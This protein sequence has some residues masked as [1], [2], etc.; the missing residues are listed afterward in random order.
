[1]K[2]GKN[3]DNS[4]KLIE[5]EFH[6]ISEAIELLKKMPK[7][8]FDS[9]C[10]VHFKLGL[11]PKQ[12]DQ[13]L[14]YTVSLPHGTGKTVRVVAFVSDDK[15][16]EA[17]AAGATFAGTEDLIEKIE[18]GWTD[19]DVAIATPD[20]MKSLGKVA[21]NL[22]QKGLMPNPKTGTVTTDV[23]KT[24]DE[25]RKGKVEVRLDKLSNTHNIFGKLS[26]DDQKLKEN[27]KTVIKSILDSRPVGAKGTYVL[28]ISICSTMSPGVRL[29][30]NN[31]IEEIK[32]A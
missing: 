29:D 3:Y 5:K 25:I 26:F 1:M 31:V 6:T 11:D 17:K 18:K 22:G 21:K 4:F 28:S 30:V 12:A 7:L 27:L 2:R 32:G 9:S 20:Q 8:K 24:I 23:V 13:N 19:F 14:R 16:K 10:E 15:I